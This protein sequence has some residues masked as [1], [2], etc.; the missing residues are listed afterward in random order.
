MAVHVQ[1]AR[2][3]V[4]SYLAFIDD[5]T[6]ATASAGQKA[7]ALL[8]VN[9]GYRRYLTGDYVDEMG[10]KQSHLWSSLATLAQITLR[11][12]DED[13]DLP[14]AY[15]GNTEPFVYDYDSLTYGEEL[16]LVNHSQLLR[17]R[18]DNNTE[19]QP[20]DYTVRAKVHAAATGTVHE[21]ICYPKPVSATVTSAGT[22]VTRVTGPDF[23]DDLVGTTI[24]ITGSADGEVQS[25][26]SA[27]VLVSDAA[28]TA[29]TA[30][31]AFY[32][33]GLTI[34]Y[35]YLAA[36]AALTDSATVYPSGLIGCGDLIVQAA[37]MLDEHDTG[38]KDGTE[39]ARYYR[40][41]GEMVK[42]DKALIPAS[43][44]LQKR[45]QR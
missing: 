13:Y 1:D 35:R 39:T 45:I 5:V 18:R 23:H 21:W 29:A 26:T 36:M 28:I 6:Y 42:R 20:T 25:V 37:R 44:N 41:M 34:R 27:D 7:A 30:T 33:N 9:D 3:I 12:G 31:E 24:E 16:K 2:A 40:M 32:D 22:T 17:F 19:G 8:A 38:G 14:A 15:E 43:Q 10:D 11:A 4:T